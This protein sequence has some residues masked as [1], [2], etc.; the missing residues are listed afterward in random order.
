MRGLADEDLFDVGLSSAS[1]AADGVAVG[2]S[3]APAED[4]ETFLTG[5]AFD[6]AFADEALLGFHGQE[7]HADAVVARVGQGVAEFLAFA[8]EELVGNLDEDAGAVTGF[9][10]AT[11]GSAMGQIDEDLDAFGDDVVGRF[12][13][14]VDYEA[15]AA[16]IVLVCRIV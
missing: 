12:G 10:V 14:D 6:D 2:G 1:L 13:V 5:D 9:G 15:E 7:H 11:A 4:G 3:V 16:S 8:G